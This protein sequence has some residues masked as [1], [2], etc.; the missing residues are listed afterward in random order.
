[1]LNSLLKCRFIH[2]FNLKSIMNR[3]S[4][5]GL[6]G[7]KN[8][9]SDGGLW[10]IPH[11]GMGCKRLTFG[12]S[13]SYLFYPLFNLVD[14]SIDRDFTSQMESMFFVSR[15]STHPKCWSFNIRSFSS[16]LE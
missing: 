3:L 8:T 12:V 2:V 16:P 13:S 10:G 4:T 7:K 14:L 6:R 15:I 5:T 11:G 9:K 1:M